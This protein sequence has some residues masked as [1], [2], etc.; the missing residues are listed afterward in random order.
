MDQLFVMRLP[1]QCQGRAEALRAAFALLIRIQA[2]RPNQQ[3]PGDKAL[4]G[5]SPRQTRR[6]GTIR[7]FRISRCP[8]VLRKQ[9]KVLE[10]AEDKGAA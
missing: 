6:T 10:P 7:L 3:K 5:I 9:Q 8:S 1:C 2:P 4:E